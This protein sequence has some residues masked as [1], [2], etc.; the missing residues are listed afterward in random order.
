MS[1][2]KYTM[3]LIVVIPV[4]FASSCR[5]VTT[6]SVEPAIENT[7]TAPVPYPL[8]AGEDVVNPNAVPFRINKP[9]IEGTTEVS[10]TGPAGVPIILV[11]VTQMGLTLAEGE[12]KE[13]GT[14]VLTT[15]VLA[16]GQRLGLSYNELP[17]SKW[18][19]K[20]FQGSGF[21]GD[22]PRTIPLVGYFYDTALV[23]EKK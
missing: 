22:E 7:P 3:I 6:L 21:N 9:V 15:P 8:P 23:I 18:T 16:K 17:G 20:D 12:I 14:W 4:L 10:G 2:K 19:A 1:M 13:D 11:D 5:S